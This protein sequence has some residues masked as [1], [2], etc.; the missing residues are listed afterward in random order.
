MRRLLTSCIFLFASVLVLAQIRENLPLAKPLFNL[1][2]T[3]TI[4][5]MGDVMMHADQISNARQ[6]D[7]SYSFD[8][9]FR[10]M[11][12]FIRSSDLAVANMEFTLAGKPYSGYPCFSAPDGYETYVAGCGVDV[13]LTAN[14]HILDKGR[15]G[16]SRTL[17]RYSEM[18]GKGVIKHTGVS[19][20]EKDDLSRFPLMVVARGVRLALVNFTYG[21]NLKAEDGFPKVHSINRKEIAEAIRRAKD[22]GA[23]FIVALPHWGT[24]Y[25]LR[26]SREQEDLAS[27]L[28]GQ[29]CDAVVGAHPHVVQDCETIGDVP[30]VYSMGN[31]VS[32][33]SARNTQVGMAVRLRIVTDW[34]GKRKM[35]DPEFIFTWCSRP[36]TLTG[37]YSVV[38]V[39]EFVGKRDLWKN[40]SDY[41]NMVLS[42]ERVKRETGIVD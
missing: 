11:E 17:E 34:S 32:N 41:D 40:P 33:M 21:T 3:V 31:A 42:Y 7:G 12:D 19:V 4:F 29:G 10:H 6:P 18:E 35:I 23:E 36:G 30:V 26:H 8:T 13:F 37:S 15:R 25:V 16:L 22:A 38:P 20:S 39:K 5:L 24:E 14:N 28:V 9:Y 27:W 2:D 1:P